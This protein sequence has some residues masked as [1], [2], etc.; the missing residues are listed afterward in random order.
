MKELDN[1]KMGF[2]LPCIQ[3]PKFQGTPSFEL[4]PKLVKLLPKFHELVQED[5]YK[6]IKEFNRICSS[7]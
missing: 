6:H 4:K 2:Q 7:M 3:M 5:P 1:H